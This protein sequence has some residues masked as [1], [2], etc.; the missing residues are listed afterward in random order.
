MRFEDLKQA[1][2]EDFVEYWRKDGYTKSEPVSYF[3][4][5]FNQKSVRVRKAIKQMLAEDVLILCEETSGNEP[6]YRLSPMAYMMTAAALEEQGKAPPSP[7]GEGWV[8]AG[9]IFE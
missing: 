4:E 2:Y 6:H 9:G 5:L 8:K 3:V 1:I 7:D